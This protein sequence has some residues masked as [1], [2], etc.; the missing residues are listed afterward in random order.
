[1]KSII[2][3]IWDISQFKCLPVHFTMHN[4]IFKKMFTYVSDPIL[5]FDCSVFINHTLHD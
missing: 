3:I 5:Q 1:M 2:K 4:Q